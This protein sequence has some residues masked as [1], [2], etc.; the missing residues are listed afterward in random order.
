MVLRLPVL[1]S[2]ARTPLALS[3]PPPDFAADGLPVL[4]DARGR[5]YRYLRLSVTDRCDY[6]CVYC[7]PPG[8]EHEHAVRPEL[9]SFEEVVRLVGVLARSG[10]SRVRFTGGEPLVR[11]DLVRLVAMVHREAPQ[12]ELALTSNASRLAALAAPLA[13]AGLTG[14]NVSLDSLDPSRF[15]AITRGGEL[16]DVLA[17]IRAALAVGLEVKLNTVVLGGENDHELEALVDFAFGL[18]ITPRFIELMP[19][20]EAA[21]LPGERFVPWRSLYARL[22][23]RLGGELETAGVRGPARYFAAREGGGR[24]VGFITAVSDEFCGDC[25]RVRITARGDLR[26]CLASRAAVSLCDVMR[27]GGSD[28]ELAWALHAALGLKQRGHGFGDA[29]ES[30][31]ERVGMSLIGG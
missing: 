28:R 7:M 25:N 2:R 5:V 15:R 6:A 17:G 9:L 10:I 16:G 24:K 29:D 11:R 31:H 21:A 30:E 8:G 19:L 27:D 20:G 18:G 3:P 23:A 14:V 13:A 22:A 12:L 1:P 26:A 4:A